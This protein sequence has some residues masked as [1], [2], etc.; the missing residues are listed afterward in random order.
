MRITFLGTGTSHGVP[1]LGCA[2]P[3]CSSK[4]PRD[5]RWRSSL[6]VEA[7][8]LALV[9]DAGPEF[10]LQALRAGV[11]R[12]DALLVTHAH[13]DHI[14]GLDD[15]RPLTRG[16]VLPVYAS[17]HDSAEIRQR[18]SYVFSRGQEDGGKPRFELRSLPVGAP[19][20][21]TL[22]ALG[23]AD[24]EA[25]RS[26][27]RVQGIPL[28]HGHRTVLG[29]RIGGLAYLTDCSSIPEASLARLSGLELLVLD[30]LRPRPPPTHL[31]LGEA[32]DIARRL[33]PKRLL[34]TH[35]CHDL[36]HGE[37]E[38]RCALERLP[39]PA[40]PAYDGLSIEL[41]DQ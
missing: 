19:C 31:S 20:D 27:L 8:G 3:V 33:A 14:H 34:L 10:R 5:A 30:A 18:F 4:D 6:S 28:L 25:P 24:G 38:E 11:A 36:S 26:T 2:C 1:V 39:F 29:Y 15:I 22:E 23:P 21:F 7:R 32:L 12:L 37:L 16:G 35:L 17:E 40:G 13:A 9:I 41:I